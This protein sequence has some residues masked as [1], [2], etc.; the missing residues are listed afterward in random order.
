MIVGAWLMYLTSQSIASKLILAVVSYL[1]KDKGFRGKAKN[2]N[3]NGNPS[4]NFSA[5]T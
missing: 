1:S 4:N 5:S 2:K 3:S